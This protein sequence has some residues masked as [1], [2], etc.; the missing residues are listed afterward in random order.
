MGV[1]GGH[2]VGG[3]GWKRVAQREQHSRRQVEA[4][5]D[6]QM[7]E[8]ERARGLRGQRSEE[9]AGQV[10]AGFAGHSKEFGLFSILGRKIPARV[11]AGQERGWGAFP[12]ESWGFL[13]DPRIWDAQLEKCAMG[14]GNPLSTHLGPVSELCCASLSLFC[15]PYWLS[16][17]QK[18]SQ[19]CWGQRPRWSAQVG[20]TQSLA[21]SSLCPGYARDFPRSQGACLVDAELGAPVNT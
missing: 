17:A 3:G 15:S 12:T 16:K 1:Q 14:L 10:V 20:T 21:W 18:P 9:Q 11:S 2:Y 6:A 7:A 8:P 4:Q 19:T 5:K 13:R